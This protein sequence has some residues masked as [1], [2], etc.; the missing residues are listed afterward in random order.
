MVTRWN[1]Y[2]ASAEAVLRL[3]SKISDFV[4]SSSVGASVTAS[5]AAQTDLLNSY[6][7]KVLQDMVTLLK[8]L[9]QITIDEEGKLY[10]T[11][12]AVIPRLQYAKKYTDNVFDMANGGSRPAEFSQLLMPQLVKE[13]RPCF[14]ELWA[15]YIK[16]FIDDPLLK[17]ASLVDIRYVTSFHASQ[18]RESSECLLNFT[19]EQRARRS[20]QSTTQAA[21]AGTQLASRR[22]ATLDDSSSALNNWLS[23]VQPPVLA[24]QVDPKAEVDAF[25]WFLRDCHQDFN[26]TSDPLDFLRLEWIRDLKL[27]PAVAL[28]VLAVPAGEAPAERIFSIA[29]RVLG[30]SRV[31]MTSSTLCKLVFLKKNISQSFW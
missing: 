28:D 27:V 21:N 5:M 6:G 11:A 12:S 10:I 16:K 17:V 14:D 26:M 4:H 29:S 7:Y 25:C 30:T 22:A 8:P 13:W 24:L 15:K 19:W 3:K 31:S 1:S 2:I 9:M 23:D 20:V 18:L